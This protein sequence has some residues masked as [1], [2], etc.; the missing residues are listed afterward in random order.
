MTAADRHALNLTIEQGFLLLVVAMLPLFE[1]PKSIALTGYLIAAAVRHL[2]FRGVGSAGAVGWV[3]LAFVGSTIASGVAAFAFSGW[4]DSRRL[5][6]TGEAITYS[7]VLMAALAGGYDAR[8]RR[9]ASWTALLVAGGLSV[10]MILLYWDG[11]RPGGIL[12]LGNVNTAALYIA[13]TMAATAALLADALAA[14]RAPS[15]V[16]AS[17]AL[18]AQLLLIIDLGSRTGLLA[19]VAG[20]GGIGVVCLGCRGAAMVLG[21]AVLCAPIVWLRNQYLATKFG[22]ISLD[23]LDGLV[24][25]RADMWR[26]G[27]AAFLDNPVLGVGWRNMRYVDQQ[28]LGFDFPPDSE[29]ANADHAHNQFLNLL[30]EG[31]IFGFVIVATLAGLVSLRL[32]RARP[33]IPAVAPA[34]LAGVG[35]LPALLVGGLFELVIVAE[36]ALMAA[37]MLGLAVGSPAP[38]PGTVV[39]RFRRMR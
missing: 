29:A 22:Q 17:V 4:D 28:A 21:L 6:G 38:S 5:V 13:L 25:A 14:R 34:W 9:L 23:G 32:W 8:F 1:S 19:V 15:A 24:G 30:A 35:A 26:L 36:V 2:T 33:A 10:W 20:L 3:V 16:I 7:M 39:A 37:L 27:A 12:S 11:G 31:G 18:L